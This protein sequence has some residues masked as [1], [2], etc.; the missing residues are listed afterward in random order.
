MQVSLQ[1]LKAFEAAA[2]HGSFKAAAEELSL[3]PTAISHHVQNLESR[4]S[5]SLFHRSVRKIQLTQ[6]G[7]RLADAASRGFRTIEQ[8]L[9]EISLAG[10]KIQVATTTSFAS[11]VL[12]P[13]LEDFQRQFPSIAVEVSS[14]ESIENQLYSLPIRFGNTESVAAEDILCRETFDVF[15]A[16]SAVPAL[17]SNNALRIA[18]TRWK[19]PALQAPPI[20]SW[21]ANNFKLKPDIEFISHDQ[22]LIGIQQAVMGKCLVFCSV[23]LSKPFVQGGLLAPVGSHSVDTGYCYYCPDKSHYDSNNN[24]LFLHWLQALLVA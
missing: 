4:L 18:L 8:A 9:E 16:P 11:L 19:N 7:K 20:D 23:T 13:A 6:A 10:R 12:I 24:Q 2:R 15:G 3:S 17:M 22:E 21:L 14:G 1:A 5:L